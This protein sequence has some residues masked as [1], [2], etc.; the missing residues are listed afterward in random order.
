M[1][2]VSKPTRPEFQRVAEDT[3]LFQVISIDGNE[4]R[5]KDFAATGQPYD[6]FTL[7]KQSG[8]ANE[9]VEQVSGTPNRIRPPKS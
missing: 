2:D 3:Q 8:R 4:L 1:Y 6:G 9:L 7:K 5:Y